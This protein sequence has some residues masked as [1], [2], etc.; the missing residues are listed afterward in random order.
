MK[1]LRRHP[2]LGHCPALRVNIHQGLD[3]F[4]RELAKFLLEIGHVHPNA[5]RMPKQKVGIIITTFEGHVVNWRVI[6][7]PV[8]REG[9]TPSKPVRSSAPSLN[10]LS[11]CLPHRRYQLRAHLGHHHLRINRNNAL[12]TS[13]PWEWEEEGNTR[14]LASI[15]LWNEQTSAYTMD[16]EA[17]ERPSSPK[18]KHHRLDQK[19]SRGL[20]KD[21]SP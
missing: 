10:T 15:C 20:T 18:P 14:S 19:D 1:C 6:T 5:Y 13:R 7:R 2:V 9:L 8:L 21:T 16:Q 17:E 4:L 3:P 12:W 11:Y